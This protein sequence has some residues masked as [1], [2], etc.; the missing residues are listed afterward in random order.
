MPREYFA[1]VT[2]RQ[3]HITIKAER[4]YCTYKAP[5][6][7]IKSGYIYLVIQALYAIIF[8]DKMQ[9]IAREVAE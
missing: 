6:G 5:G 1:A 7:Y 9:D 3:V 8:I 2:C 4:A